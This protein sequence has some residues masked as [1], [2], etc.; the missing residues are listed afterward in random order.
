MSEDID[1]KVEEVRKRLSKKSKPSSV[2]KIPE[3]GK[4]DPIPE[5]TQVYIKGMS[6]VL[7]CQKCG[8]EIIDERRKSL[9]V[10]GK[11]YLF[12]KNCNVSY[13]HDC[14]G[15]SVLVRKV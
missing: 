15:Y 11:V 9:N 12:C 2:E 14:I 5:W 10:G 1:K 8:N 7:K 4:P 13:Y 3:E 6:A